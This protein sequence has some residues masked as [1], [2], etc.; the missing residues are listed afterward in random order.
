MINRTGEAYFSADMR[1]VRIHLRPLH[2]LLTESVPA[3][4]VMT[5]SAIYS[6]VARCRHA[7]SRI[8]IELRLAPTRR[9]NFA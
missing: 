9:N 7:P 1:L 6:L 3:R 2:R 8:S 5:A 4:A